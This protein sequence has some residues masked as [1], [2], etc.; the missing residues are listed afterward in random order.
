MRDLRFA[1][2]L[3]LRSPGFAVTAV[4]CLALG[5]GATTAV[6]TV[7]NAVVLR[8]LPY[9]DSNRM[10]R[11]YSEFPTFPNGG[12]RRFT[13]SPPEYLEMRDGL[14]SYEH[15][16]AWLT[17][18][19]NLITA[20]EP[21][22]MTAT[23]VTGTLFESLGVSPQ[24]GRWIMEAD[25]QDGAP[26]TAVISDGLWRRAFGGSPD[27]IGRETLVDG[28]PATIVGV[29]P[30]GF[31]YPPGQVDI[32]EVWLPLQFSAALRQ[33]RASHFLSVMAKLRANTSIEQA[34][35]ELTAHIAVWG[36]RQSN[37]FHTIQP[38]NHPLLEFGMQDEVVRGVRPAMLVILGAVGFV[39]LIACLNV[40]NLLLARAEARQKEIAVRIA[41][42]SGISGLVRQFIAEGLLISTAG[43]AAGLGIAFLGL[44]LLLWAG[45]GTIP[46]ASEVALDWRVL[47]FTGAVLIATAFVF[48]LVPLA[49]AISRKTYE[50]LKAAAGRTSATAKA[51]A[52][53]R[54]LVVAELSLALVLLISCGLML[55]A[56]WRL[57]AVDAG[58]EPA[59][60]L[61]MRV[62][63]P[64]AQY[65]GAAAASFISRME[66]ALA[67]LPGV[68]SSTV[69]TGLPPQRPG[70]FNDTYIENFV[71]R[72]GGPIQNVDYWQFT[73]D[74]F[75]ETLR[76]RLVEGRYLKESDSQEA[77]PVAVI[78]ETMARAFWPGQSALGHRLRLPQPTDTSWRTI[79]GVVSDIKNSGTD[80]PTGTELFIPWRQY[81]PI[82][83]V[84]D[85]RRTMQVMVRTEGAPL[86]MVSAVRAA[87]TQLDPSLPVAAVR[88]MEEV[89]SQSQSRPRFL[90]V[91]LTFFT[92]VALALA[93]IGVYGVI[94]YSV[95]RRTGEIGIR[96]ALGADAGRILLMVLKQ[97]ALLGAV[98]I[99]VGV[100]VAVSLTRFLRSILFAVEPVDVPTFAG[101]IVVLFAVTL[102]ASWIPARRATRIDPTVALRY[103]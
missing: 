5:M 92:T 94:S 14:K 62:A 78:N 86:S 66:E 83:G 13:I 37:N 35:Q 53:R 44:R 6:F 64:A 63:M 81:G 10:V 4:L 79:V 23:R 47:G 73:G 103:D 55:Q 98:G 31:E 28:T 40:A 70:N 33:L 39:L 59:N 88:T 43:A 8:P 61:T 25:A 1:W 84:G 68:T 7:V 97:G 65:Q 19:V 24:R 57:Q 21:V 45:S 11:I 93:A 30:A 52:L 18:A 75:F 16:D 85:A 2:R 72:Q 15:I 90:S 50:T 60:L 100:G 26:V 82:A 38:V 49:Q 9:K 51:A 87:I 95:A 48:G 32:S 76:A 17:G 89:V 27:V 34:R 42:G 54:G 102:L 99:G 58:F 36:E 101:T 74:H 22:R 69:A 12:L 3:L 96:M 20:K 41:M 29:M 91:L 56:F 67:R 71:P 77:P 46:R 80:Q